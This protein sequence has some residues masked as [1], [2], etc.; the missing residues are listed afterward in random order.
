MVNLYFI[1]T[2]S[3]HFNDSPIH[4]LIG[5]SYTVA[6]AAGAH[7]GRAAIAPLGPRTNY[8]NVKPCRGQFSFRYFNF[9]PFFYHCTIISFS[10]D[11]FLIP[12]WGKISPR[13]N[14]ATTMLHRGDVVLSLMIGVCNPLFCPQV[15]FSEYLPLH[16]IKILL[17]TTFTDTFILF[18]FLSLL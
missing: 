14:V 18:L 11:Q 15:Y 16:A 2:S 10:S 1:R 8:W 17:E 3:A 5:V 6:T 13:Y 12:R 7:R 9:A 4:L